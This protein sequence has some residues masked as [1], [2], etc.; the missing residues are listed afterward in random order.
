MAQKTIVCPNCGGPVPPNTTSP[1]LACSYC[2]H[3]FENPL[4][5]K[6]TQQPHAPS[7]SSGT[8]K[9]VLTVVLLSVFGFPLLIGGI[10]FGIYTYTA[11]KTELYTKE[12]QNKIAQFTPPVALPAPQPEKLLAPEVRREK[13]LDIYIECVQASYPNA[14]RAMD[15][16]LSWMKTPN[17]GPSC[18]E[19]YVSYGVYALQ[20]Y[21][22][23]RCRK[24]VNAQS[25]AP[26]I[27][28]LQTAATAHLKAVEAALP[29][30]NEANTYYQQER[31]TL[32][33][34]R[35]GQA[36]HPKLMQTFASLEST[37][38]TL[39]ATLAAENKGTLARCLA[40]TAKDPTLKGAY[41]VVAF[42][43]FSQQLVNTLAE[44]APKKS[45]NVPRIKRLATTLM[46]K[47][48]ALQNMSEAHKESS[49]YSHITASSVENF[50]QSMMAFVKSGG[51]KQLDSSARFFIRNGR[52]RREYAGTYENLRQTFNEML[53]RY[54]S[55]LVPCGSL[56]P[57]TEKGCPER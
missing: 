12:I 13:I 48:E 41:E 5:E 22:L 37:Y 15:R 16:Y 47:S 53:E 33:D 17:K 38:K 49:G 2:R 9:S 45:P 30:F 10:I 26:A 54:N 46:E 55:D 57:C 24:M 14:Q 18:K 34:C 8:D 23:N 6:V 35:K 1:S 29:V 51:G 21:M 40:R 4:Y 43:A 3:H 25:M 20:E 50:I 56:L 27:P 11:S 39:Y 44:E 52:E 7:R 28:A 31:Y 42:M 36:L 32:D 19:R